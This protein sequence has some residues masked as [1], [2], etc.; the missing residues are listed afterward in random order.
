MKRTVEIVLAII[1]ILGYGL[2]IAFGVVMLVLQNNEAILQDIVEQTPEMGLGDLDTLIEG[3][4]TGGWLILIVAVLAIILSI[5]AI[6]LIKGN[7]HPKSAGIIFVVTSILGAVITV[8]FGIFPG[9]FILIAGIM[10][11]VRKPAQLIQ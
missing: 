1:G 3:L 4:S 11:F 10:C 8:G 5:V 9:I 2:L 7:K 6:F